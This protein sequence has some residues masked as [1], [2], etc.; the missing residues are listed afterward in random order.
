[1]KSNQT[2]AFLPASVFSTSNLEAINRFVPMAG[3]WWWRRFGRRHGRRRHCCRNDG[4]G[5]WGNAVGRPLLPACLSP[6]AYPSAQV[7][8]HRNRRIGHHHHYRWEHDRRFTHRFNY[9]FIRR[10]NHLLS[11]G[12][13]RC[14]RRSHGILFLASPPQAARLK[15]KSSRAAAVSRNP[16]PLV[17]FIINFF[18]SILTIIHYN[19]GHPSGKQAG[20]DYEQL[21]METAALYRNRPRLRV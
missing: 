14:S 6:P 11:A 20:R 21:L 5:C 7:F 18:L 12:S 4:C 1:M 3:R 2:P 16:F 10:F 15:T 8:R 13:G 9:R 19:Q 17:M